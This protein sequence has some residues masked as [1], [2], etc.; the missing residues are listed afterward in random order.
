MAFTETWLKDYN[1]DSHGISGF[2]HEHLTRE[3]RPGGG[4]SLFIKDSWSYR[5]RTDLSHIDNDIEMLWAEIDKD[6]L[7]NSKNTI[8][9]V[10]Y[11]R[12]GSDPQAF[13]EKLNSTLDII[14]R[15]NKFCIHTGDYNLNLLNSST[16][17][18]TNDFIDIN[19]AH[20]LFPIINKPTRISSTTATIIDNIFIDSS[21]LDN[22]KSG[23]LLWNISDHFPVFYIHYAEEKDKNEDKFKIGRIHNLTNK[24][25]FTKLINEIDWSPVTDSSD[26]QIAYT[27][28][29][30]LLTEAYDQAFLIT[31]TKINYSNRLPW[32]TPGLKK[33]IFT[34]IN[35]LIF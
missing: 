31:K 1:V 21:E 8:I 4:T 33:S 22:S 30:N 10:I 32:L 5:I 20:A 18:P 29:H 11:R 6:S 12:P 34:K 15:E 25:K 7:L 16:H 27:T 3:D 23:I 28:F 17:P 9:G 19:F 13:I 26:T 14:N 24:A 35:Y 2:S